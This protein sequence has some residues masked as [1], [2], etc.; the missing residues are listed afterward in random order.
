MGPMRPVFLWLNANWLVFLIPVFLLAYY[1]SR[2]TIAFIIIAE[3]LISYFL[4][5]LVEPYNQFIFIMAQFIVYALFVIVTRSNALICMSYLLFLL[6]F[7]AQ[8][9]LDSNLALKDAQYEINGD[10]TSYNIYEI[11]YNLKDCSFYAYHIFVV[12]FINALMIK[13]LF[14]DWGKGY[15]SSGIHDFINRHDDTNHS[16][17]NA[18]LCRFKRLFKKS[19][20][21]V[22]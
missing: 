5:S 12:P 10:L 20:K 22:V 19:N 8:F 16:L 13:G 4:A 6:Y 17:L 11:A 18:C 7:I 9:A 2:N 21:G 3:I 14:S 15:A 1:K